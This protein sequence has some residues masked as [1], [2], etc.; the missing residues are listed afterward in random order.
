[1]LLARNEAT[2][3]NFVAARQ[4]Q[5]RVLALKGET[6]TA[7]DYADHADLLVLAAGGYVSPEAE[8]VLSE[9]L[10][11]DRTNGTARYY[12]GLLLVQTGRPDLGFRIWRALLEQSAPGDPWID[13]IRAQIEDLAVIAGETNFTL[14]PLGAPPAAPLR[15]PTAGDVAAAADMTPEE[16]DQMI[17]GMVAGLSDRLAT[18][19]GPPEE[20]ARLIGA[21]GVL[22]EVDQARAIADEAETVFADDPLALAQIT[23]ARARAGLE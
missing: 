20:W 1:M 15:G 17:R 7:A 12:S 19:G 5:A 14:P 2:L 13:P 11:R 8:V 10:T 6:A 4:A 21:L 16:R 9:A 3:G 18:E 22:G 23:E